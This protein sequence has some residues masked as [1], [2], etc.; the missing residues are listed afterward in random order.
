MPRRILSGLLAIALAVPLALGD[1]PAGS[2]RTLARGDTVLVMQGTINL[3]AYREFLRAVSRTKPDLVIME[4]PGGV[5]GEAMMIA[6]EIRARRIDTLVSPNRSC[7]SA[8]AVI[9][10]AGRT[11][12][13][14]RGAAVGLHSARFRDGRRSREGTTIMAAYLRRLGVPQSILRR[15]ERT[16]PSEIA[17]LSRSDQRALRIQAVD[18]APQGR[19]SRRRAG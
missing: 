6:D 14:G 17:W 19:G 5:L 10:L 12:Y 7:A 4:G 13:L 16:A 9:F 2:A 8:C 15:M 11:K 1:M 18:T 3:G